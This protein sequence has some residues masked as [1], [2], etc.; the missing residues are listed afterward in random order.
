MPNHGPFPHSY[1]EGLGT[2]SGITQAEEDAVETG[3]STH[4][5]FVRMRKETLLK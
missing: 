4:N 2:K 1:G 5:L 3:T